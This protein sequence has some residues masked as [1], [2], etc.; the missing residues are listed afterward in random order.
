MRSSQLCLSA[1]GLASTA[2]AGPQF[3]HRRAVNEERV[4]A[5]KEAYRTA[6]KGYYDYAFPNDTLHPVSNGYENDRNAWGVTAFDSLSASIILGD[7]ESVNQILEFVPTI[8]FTT[9]AA[10]GESISLFETNIRYFGGLLSVVAH[11]LLTQAPWSDLVDDKSL[12]DSLL[13][14]AVSLADSVKFAF[15]TPSGVPDPTIYL[16]PEPKLAGSSR[17]NIAEVGTLVLEWTRLSDLTGDP[18]YAQLAQKAE[19]YILKPTPESGEPFPGLTGTYLNLTDGTFIDSSGGWS[20]LTDSYYEY[21]IKMYLYDPEEF[22]FYKDRWVAA[23]DSTIEYLASH[24]TSREDITFLSQYQGTQTIPSSS[25]LASFAGGNFILGGILLNEQKYIDFG[26][27][28]AESYFETYRGTAAKIGPEGFRWTDSKLPVDGTINTN[29]PAG[30]EEAYAEAG[31]WATSKYYILRPETTES[32]YYA[33]RVTGDTKYQDLA[34]EGFQAITAATRTG[35]GFAGLNDVTVTNG[36]FIDKMESFFLTETLKYFYLIFSEESE[37]QV[38]KDQPNKWVFN[39]EAHPVK[40]R[41][42]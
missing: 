42:Y 13:K 35:S 1:L 19:S 37:V 31:F 12:V 26:I 17:N 27:T 39:T 18:E 5:V 24:P 10:S 25:H 6:W 41:G 4:D 9:T 40:I 33:Y 36:G 34:W 32:L 22:S 16:N 23:A 21:L 20:G 11:D 30:Q 15:D 28:L 29:P 2:F 38:H 7:R 3:R 8:D 14:Q